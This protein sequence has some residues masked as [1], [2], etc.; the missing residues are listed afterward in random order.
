MA[1]KRFAGDRFS[2]LS[3]DTKPTNVLSGALFH[4]TDTQKYF[5]FDGS[6]WVSAPYDSVA[7]THGV[8]DDGAVQQFTF[9]E[10]EDIQFAASGATSVAFDAPNKRV[11]F[12]S[13]DTD[14]TYTAGNG[15]DLAA[16]EFSIDLAVDSGLTVGAGGLAVDPTIA[17]TR[18]SFSAGVLSADPTDLAMGGTGDSRTITSSTGSNVSVP[19]ASETDAGFMSIGDKAKVNKL[20]FNGN[21]EIDI[22]IIPVEA[23]SSKV[24]A[25]ITARDAIA[26][27]DR[28]EG[29]RVHVLD[30]S[31]DASVDSGAAGYI[32]K[33]GL[34][35][36]DW[37][38]TYESESLDIDTYPSAGS[39]FD[40]QLG[41]GA[42]GFKVVTGLA[43]DDTNKVAQI[44]GSMR[45]KENAAAVTPAH[46]EAVSFVET[47]VIDADTI[48]RVKQR[49]GNGDDV[50]I[51]SYIQ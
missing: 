41:D 34:T 47:E 39:N 42:S 14:T 29:L 16:G 17:G 36:T 26:T 15:L 40:I 48:T 27:A 43:W 30:A 44:P 21:D 33:A 31:A 2:G 50:I 6:S 10:G 38:K 37:A 24:V 49:L 5:V 19:T 11:T 7:H 46:D 51:A 8:A 23:K 18:L 35:N 4:E 32:L 1:I 20:L 22:T 28:F 3:T 45:I 12:S 25:D 13:T 9:A